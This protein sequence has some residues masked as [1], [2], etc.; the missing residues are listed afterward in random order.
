MVHLLPWDR[1]YIYMSPHHRDTVA[2]NF[3]LFLSLYIIKP[4]VPL[5]H[6]SCS[7]QSPDCAVCLD[8]YARGFG[9]SCIECSGQRRSAMI[10]FTAVVVVALVASIVIGIQSL[11]VDTEA[12]SCSPRQVLKMVYHQIR[13]TR[14][15]QALKIMV[16]SWQIVTQ[17]SA[18]LIKTWAIGVSML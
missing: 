1:I 12:H 5:R 15:S 13:R 7:H 18:F 2:H 4:T 11:E 16:V 10:A 3:P 14:A 8:G 17:A 9:N 6:A